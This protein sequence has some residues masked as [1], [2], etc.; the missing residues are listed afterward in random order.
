[1]KKTQR[2]LALLLAL[3]LCMA[4]LAAC[5]GAASSS[6]DDDDDNG[7]KTAETTAATNAET[8]AAP[9]TPEQLIIGEWKTTLKMGPAI[10]AGLIQSMGAGSEKYF[11]NVNF[12]TVMCMKF[13]EDK[14]TTVY[15]DKAS[16][17]AAATECINGLKSGMKAMFQDQYGAQFEQM[18]SAQGYASVDAF[19]D[20]ALTS[21]GLTADSL[22][23]Q[24]NNISSTGTYTIEG[25]TLTITSTTDP[26]TVEIYTFAV[27]ENALNLDMSDEEKAKFEG[28]P[29]G[30]I[31]IDL[32]PFVLTRK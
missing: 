31:A 24:I 2:L 3:I 18:V 22:A 7:T 5:D 25:N 15:Y 4:C 20:A 16:T 6:D 14:K 29:A 30:N 28:N 32:L 9:A 26:N 11:S 27:T 13:T 17:T 1:M 23:A 8:T 19:L 21:A 10:T 12:N